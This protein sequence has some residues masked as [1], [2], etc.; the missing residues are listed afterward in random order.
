MDSTV[1]VA[2][3]NDS[4]AVKAYQTTDIGL[5]DNI[6]FRPTVDDLAPV[7]ARQNAD[8]LIAWDCPGSAAPN[9]SALVPG[10]QNTYIISILLLEFGVLDFQVGYHRT[11]GDIPKQSDELRDGPVGAPLKGQVLDAV[12]TTIEDTGKGGSSPQVCS[13]PWGDHRRS[14]EPAAGQVGVQVDIV[15]EDEV[16]VEQ[17]GVRADGD[18]LLSRGDLVRIVRLAYA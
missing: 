1:S 2:I 3:R 15:D 18:K 13:L 5:A 4:V 9:D 6:P 10:D 16:L 17:V 11:S 8:G 7:E 14:E 12:T